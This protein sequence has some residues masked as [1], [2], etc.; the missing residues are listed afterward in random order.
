MIPASPPADGTATPSSTRRRALLAAT[1]VALAGGL[2][3][4][5]GHATAAPA[6]AQPVASPGSSE[7]AHRITLVTGDVVTFTDGPGARDLVT[8]APEAQVSVEQYGDDIFAVPLDAQPLISAGKVDRRLFNVTDLV[9]M[10]YDD[11]RTGGRLPVIATYDAKTARSKPAAPRGSR[12]AKRL[13]SIGG[14]AL[15]V[16]MAERRSFWKSVAGSADDRALEGGITGL[17]L[18]GKADAALKDSVPQI[19][20]PEA[21]GKG[22]DGKGVKVA[23]LDTGIDLGH[24]DVK[25]RVTVARSF[26]PGE[27]VED[28]NGHGTHVAS[29][30][31]GSGAA[32]GGAYKGV[33]P[34][35]DLLIGKVLGNDGSGADSGIIEA[36]EWA[37]DQG[38]D[39]VSM[40]LGTPYGDSGS[41]PMS[42]AVDALS[43]NGGPLYVVA[44]GNAGAEGSVSAPGSAEK[45]LTVAAVNKSDARASFSSQGPL[46]RSHALKPDISAP[47]VDIVA[48]ASQ[49]VP[50]WTGGMYRSMDGTSMATPHVAGAA[51]ILHQQHPD[52][53]GEQ[54]KDALMSTSKELA[55]TP[56]SMGTGRVDVAAAVSST[57]TA[58][59][60][61]GAAVYTWPHSADE[62][63]TTRTV[64][65]TNNGAEDITL[66][67]A[68]DTTDQAYTLAD[69]EISVPAGGTARTTLTLD[70]AGVAVDTSFSGQVVAADHATGA[71]VAHT[72]FAL[73]KEREL[74]DVTIKL[75]DR[76]GKP[77]T[78][79]VTLGALGGTE[80]VEP[81][82]AGEL[83]LR[84]APGNY[85]AWSHLAVEGEAPDAHAT[86]FLVDPETKVTDGPA[87]IVL[88]A[89]K[90][91]RAGVRTPKASE[92]SQ[93]RYDMARTAPNGKVMR[94]TTTLPIYGDELWVSPTEP[95]TE[96]GFSYLTRWRQTE[97]GFRVHT[98]N[99]TLNALTQPGSRKT[100]DKFTARAVYAG[101]GAAEDYAGLDAKGKAVVIDRSSAVPPAKRAANAAAA[102]AKVL[103]V[104]NDGLGRPNE[105]YGTPESPA[106]LP[107]AG[108][109]KAE[110]A[111]LLGHVAEHGTL[112][113]ELDDDPDYL[114]DLVSRHKDTVPDRPLVYAP[115][116]DR[117]LAKVV[118]TFHGDRDMLGGGYRYDLP[119]NGAGVGFVQYEAYPGQRTEWV[120]PLGDGYK[121]ME[122]HQTLSPAPLQ[123]YGPPAD[124]QAGRSYQR[125]WFQPVQRPRMGTA[126]TGPYRDSNNNLTLAVEPWTD[127]GPAGTSGIGDGQFKT[128][129]YRDGVQVVQSAGRS[130]RAPG[131][132]AEELPYTLVMDASRDASV[133][134]TSTRTHTEWEF[135]SKAIPAGTPGNR[136]DVRL[137]QLDY[138]IDTDLAGDVR[139]GAPVVLTLSSGTQEW[140]PSPVKANTATLSVSYDDGATWKPVTL[141]RTAAGTWKAA[142]LP[143]KNK[144]GGFVSLMASAEA[145]GG[146]GI[147]Q[148]IIR[149]VGLR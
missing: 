50:G 20:A 22:F 30:I 127:S 26:V 82:V 103:I 29:T 27:E 89:S 122:T 79:T 61:V 7:S 34:G 80:V 146:L 113:L 105:S 139:A 87:T 45:A 36:M 84:V 116:A 16:D 125:R 96:G 135:A 109:R 32:S 138:G 41:D 44:A 17:W 85:V 71:V 124:V 4:P 130:V 54:L 13:E 132:P 31:A 118:N 145:D 90:A 74:Y 24:P 3:L 99:G 25:D 73:Y 37:K 114:Y 49:S 55:D 63:A 9:E 107:V 143:P 144:A 129:L 77:A 123:M 11:A 1:A 81:M 97:P 141:L 38:A 115:D 111:A 52:W 2:L 6:A 59:G 19:G 142:L 35:A 147:S 51:A 78:G 94:K 76:S 119:P 53:T 104:V 131:Q 148:E 75:R 136:R 33:A 18:D 28:G 43:A 92:T 128:V 117:D 121:W 102:G 83:T 126:F 88:D 100:T 23:V 95:V 101:A 106:A 39:V 5:L 47:G 133:W 93:W 140:L 10:G 62:R 64:T 48:A 69:R 91:R 60:S 70:P 134:H 68:T 137:L 21:W 72:G 40:S 15:T 58:T 14:A 120:S 67:L 46:T 108:V 149:A 56:Y 86:A 42:L 57:L 65:Y 98:D 66:D 8:T 12:V 112:S 110:R